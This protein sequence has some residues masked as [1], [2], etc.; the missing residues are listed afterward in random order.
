MDSG[1]HSEGLCH[2]TIMHDLCLEA[3]VKEPDHLHGF[4]RDPVV[5]Q[6]LPESD[7]FS[8]STKTCVPFQG[9]LSR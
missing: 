7:A 1:T 6:D 3:I 9:L 5:L 8:E 4:L 2:I